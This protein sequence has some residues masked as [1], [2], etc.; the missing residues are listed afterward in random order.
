MRGYRS[1][2][3]LKICC[4]YPMTIRSTAKGAFRTVKFLVLIIR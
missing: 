1:L 3:C 2:I 4:L